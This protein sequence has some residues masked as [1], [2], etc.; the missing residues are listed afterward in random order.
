MLDNWLLAIRPKTLPASVSPILLGSALAFYEGAFDARVLILALS[1]AL[2]LQI[3]VNFANDLFDG[4]AGIDSEARLGPLRVTHNGLISQKILA[5]A[6]ALVSLAAIATGV[7]L[8]GLSD[9]SLLGFG[10]LAILA[11]LA[12][13]GGPWPL[14]SHGLGEL[15]VLFFF[16]WLAVGGTYYAH[17]LNFSWTVLGFGTVAGLI[18]AAIMLVN[19]L[20]DIPTDAPAGK[21]T[22]AVRLGDKRSRQLYQTLLITALVLHLTVSLPMGPWAALAVTA[23]LPLMLSLLRRIQQRHGAEL[24]LQLAETAVLELVYCVAVSVALITVGIL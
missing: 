14:A 11:M 22:L 19:N 24:N 17:T 16:G 8:A 7:T 20:R 9:W 4:Q 5:R 23:C 3:A 15:T 6:L 13:S 21:R 10:I 18:S 1:C 12:Y 2:L